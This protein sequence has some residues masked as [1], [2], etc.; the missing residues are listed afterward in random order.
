[1]SI[2]MLT[3]PVSLNLTDASTA[4]MTNGRGATQPL[5]VGSPFKYIFAVGGSFIGKITHLHE[6]AIGYNLFID[7]DFQH[8]E[9]LIRLNN[10]TDGE[11]LTTFEIEKKYVEKGVY[12]FKRPGDSAWGGPPTKESKDYDTYK[13][14]I[15]GIIEK[16]ENYDEPMSG[17]RRKQRRRSTRRRNTR[18]RKT[19]RRSQ[20]ARI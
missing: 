11:S 14:Q 8:E 20:K 17:G 5:S 6:G 2:F 16:L 4:T 3:K 9:H 7:D 13:T 19:R 15:Q 1:M 18:S 10:I 12:M